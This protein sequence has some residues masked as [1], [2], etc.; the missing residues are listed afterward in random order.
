MS[1]EDDERDDG[2]PT[3]PQA[4][5][6]ELAF[7]FELHALSPSPPPPAADDATSPDIATSQHPAKGTFFVLSVGEGDE[8]QSF[9]LCHEQSGDACSSTTAAMQAPT[10]PMT[11]LHSSTPPQSGSSPES[12][13]RPP[14]TASQ[15]PT[16]GDGRTRPL[17]RR[18]AG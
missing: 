12:L 11:A 9:R 4:H 2:L 10:R 5:V 14:P 16:A 3:T 15:P 1:D 13:I 17:A 6:A 7:D 8:Q 18:A